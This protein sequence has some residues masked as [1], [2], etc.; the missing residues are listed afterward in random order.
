MADSTES[1]QHIETRADSLVGTPLE[2]AQ[3]R[4][5]E[6]GF[7]AAFSDDWCSWQGLFPTRELAAQAVTTHTERARRSPD[8]AYHYGA[9][10]PFVVELLDDK[11][12][13]LCPCQELESL[14]PWQADRDGQQLLRAKSGRPPLDEVLHRGHLIECHGPDDGMVLSVSSTRCFGLPAFSVIFAD[15]D[16]ESNQDGTYPDS[17]YRY[18]NNYVAREGEALC[19]SMHDRLAFRGQT[20]AQT[21]LGRGLNQHRSREPSFVG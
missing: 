3:I 12:A 2:R 7:L 16:T 6:T 17:S 21:D 18:L 14:K 8:Y 4:I 1:P 9:Q 19:V 10:S 15:P 13:Q 20:D 5:T 11:T